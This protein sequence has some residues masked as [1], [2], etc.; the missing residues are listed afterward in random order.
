MARPAL[1]RLLRDRRGVSAIEFGILAPVLFTLLLGALDFGRMFYIRQGMEYA[2]EQA[3]RYYMLN[4]SAAQSAVT[5]TLTTAMVG[6]MGG[7]LSVAYADTASCNSN[8]ALTCTT[9]TVTY[10]FHFVAGILGLANKTL[11]ATAQTVR[12]N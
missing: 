2:T 8:S 10:P 9:I 3:A 6:G 12:W 1:L 7:Q 4:P 5:Q 11:T